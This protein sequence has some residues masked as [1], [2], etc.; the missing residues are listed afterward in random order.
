MT[1]EERWS[2]I[3]NALQTVAERQALNEIEIQK[4]NAKI[5]RL[6]DKIEELAV[7]TE[8]NTAAIRVNCD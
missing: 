7:K 8:K 4:S 5:D 3:E 2:R 1:P 6:S